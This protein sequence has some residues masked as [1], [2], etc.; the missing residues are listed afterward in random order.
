MFLSDFI[1]EKG[2]AY[3]R[4]VL[5]KG[6]EGVM[7]KKK[8][9]QYEEGLRTGSWL[10]IKK[11]KTCDCVIFGY[12]RGE[13]RRGENFWRLNS[14]RFMIRTVN[15]FTWARSVQVLRRRCLEF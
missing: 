8:D 11:L 13:Q 1:E 12:T 10:K 2:E 3:Y 7:A 15:Q 4:L 14:G 6:L 5:E 9:S